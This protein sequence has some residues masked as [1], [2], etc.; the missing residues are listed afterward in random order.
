MSFCPTKRILPYGVISKNSQLV[1]SMD[2]AKKLNGRP[3]LIEGKRSKKIDTRFTEE[4][5]GLLQELEKELGLSKTELIRER[6]LHKAGVTIINARE[7]IL[8]LDGIGAEMAR[9]GNN[10]NQLAK[11]AN[12]LKLQGNL[13]PNI[14]I[15]FNDLMAEYI[16]VYQQMEI[17][18]RKIIREMGK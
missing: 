14:V 12:T 18:L 7:L 4:E 11:H 6:V 16:K 3:K 5:F 17:A 9:A 10:I 2:E 1:F 8:R 13:A 15:S